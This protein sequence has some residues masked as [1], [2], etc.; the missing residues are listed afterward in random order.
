MKRF[1][2]DPGGCSYPGSPILSDLIYGWGNE[3]WSAL[4]EYLADCIS[5][6][7]VLSGPILECGSGLSTILVGVVAKRR[8]QHHWAL[9]HDPEWAARVKRYLSKYKLDL[10]L[11]YTHPLRDYGWFCWYEPPLEL[12]A[13]SFALVICDGPPGSTKGGRYGLVSIM[14]ERLRPGCVILLDDA[15]RE[16]ERMI[17]SK[18][19]RELHAS[20]ELRGT[21]KPFIRMTILDSTGNEP[22]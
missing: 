5:S 6:A 2:V 3:S 16:Q 10:T 1:L 11:I 17:A 9:E 14:R 12:M 18:W 19:Q 8:G 22:T 21:K 4:D 13:D 15:A 20:I 7:L